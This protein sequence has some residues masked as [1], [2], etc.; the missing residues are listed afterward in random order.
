MTRPRL[1]AGDS[2][3]PISFQGVDSL[4]WAQQTAEASDATMLAYSW[5]R[6]TRIA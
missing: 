3:Q 5:L 6:L 2:R 1:V 4:Q